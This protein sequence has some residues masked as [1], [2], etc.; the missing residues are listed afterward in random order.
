MQAFDLF[1]PE[2]RDGVAAALADVAA[3]DR[4][5]I[6][7]TFVARDGARATYLFTGVPL[8][9]LGDGGVVGVGIDISEREQARADLVALNAVLEQR[10]AERTE[11]L[12]LANAE[13]DSF[14]HTVSHD[15]RTPLN[16]IFGFTQL[17]TLDYGHLLSGPGKQYLDGLTTASQRMNELIEDLLKLSQASRDAIRWE[18]VNLSAIAT[19]V[20]ERLQASSPDRAVTVTIDDGLT[21]E[22]DVRLLQIVLENLI[23]NAWKYTSKQAAA[24]IRISA[25]PGRDQPTFA[26]SDNGAGFDMRHAPRL[27]RPF[28]RLHDP[29][30][31]P[32]T[33]VG[34]ATV[35]RIIARHGGHIAAESAPEQGATFT[36][37]LGT[38]GTSPA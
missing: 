33:G 21:A 32:G 11:E 17:L 10:V 3:G 37:T 19:G 18:P 29:G 7:A 38:P 28:E 4:G 5:E 1:A 6:E 16:G 2:D 35:D 8:D 34:L 9:T 25:V 27:F 30:E 15:L 14:A 36:F 12:R 22:G 24:E 13:L 26:V 20:A 31:F 23:Q